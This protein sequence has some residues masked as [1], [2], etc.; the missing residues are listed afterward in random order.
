MQ[1]QGSECMKKEMS[2]VS[3]RLNEEW[4]RQGSE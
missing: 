2:E 1:L 4:V 3:H